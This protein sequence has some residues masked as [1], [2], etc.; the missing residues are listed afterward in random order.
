MFHPARPAQSC[1]IVLCNSGVMPAL[2]C[3]VH[4]RTNEQLLSLE[5]LLEK[6]AEQDTAPSDAGTAT[7]SDDSLEPLDLNEDDKQGADSLRSFPEC[8]RCSHLLISQ[9]TTRV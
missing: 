8:V 6:D 3:Q 7:D 4:R 1:S 9:I 5:V 2:R